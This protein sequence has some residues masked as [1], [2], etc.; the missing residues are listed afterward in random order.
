MTADTLVGVLGK[1]AYEA[2]LEHAA[3]NLSMPLSF[4]RFSPN[5][6]AALEH[7]AQSVSLVSVVSNVSLKV[8]RQLK[9]KLPAFPSAA[10]IQAAHDRFIAK[11][12]F[13][14]LGILT[15]PFA[16]IESIA[17]VKAALAKIGAPAL[18]KPRAGNGQVRI[19]SRD[20]IDGA[21]ATLGGEPGILEGAVIVEREL[22]VLG[23]RASDGEAR[24][25]RISENGQPANVALEL[26]KQARGYALRVAELVGQRGV[27]CLELF[28]VAGALLAHQ[29]TPWPV[30]AGHWTLEGART[31]QYENHLRAIAGLSL[32]ACE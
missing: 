13:K 2:E 24:F 16:G 9:A 11:Q 17:G 15:V 1:C 14:G 32:G 3:L 12:V 8:A 20:H 10:A 7:F 21:Y 4:A 28:S 30:A 22:A 26:E 29:F 25:W 27:F 31:S 6:T 18:L 19:E 23:V 5:D